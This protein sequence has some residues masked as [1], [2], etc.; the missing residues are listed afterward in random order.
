MSLFPADRDFLRRELSLHRIPP[1]HG[2]WRHVEVGFDQLL[3]LQEDFLHGAEEANLVGV[4]AMGVKDARRR[5]A[6]GLYSVRQSYSGAD[7]DTSS[8]RETP[9]A[10]NTTYAPSG[11]RVT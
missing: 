9:S 5:R 7:V 4:V 8:N 3:V 6:T 10:A 11:R 1:E 2:Q